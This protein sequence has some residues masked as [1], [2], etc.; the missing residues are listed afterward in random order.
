MES[1]GVK[2]KLFTFVLLELS[3]A[4]QIGVGQD[5]AEQ[6]GANSP[7][8]QT[9]LLPRATCSLSAFQADSQTERQSSGVLG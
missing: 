8:S 9:K 7:G 5:R 1:P 6:R 3:K 2:S 4:G